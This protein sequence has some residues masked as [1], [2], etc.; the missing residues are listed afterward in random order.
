M[1]DSDSL[2]PQPCTSINDAADCVTLIGLPGGG[3]RVTRYYSS[4][5]SGNYCKYFK[6]PSDV[7]EY[8]TCVY[9]CDSDVMVQGN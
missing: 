9:T 8:Q 2:C 6:R 1:D 7:V 4:H 5:N 3:L